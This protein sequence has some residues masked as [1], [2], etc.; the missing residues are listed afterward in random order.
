SSQPDPQP[1]PKLRSAIQRHIAQNKHKIDWHNWSILG[2]D[3]H[4]YRLLVKESLAIAENLPSLNQTTRSVPLIVFSE[5]S[6]T[7]RLTLTKL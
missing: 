4:P 7:R 6:T 3:K 2:R 1:H 5:G